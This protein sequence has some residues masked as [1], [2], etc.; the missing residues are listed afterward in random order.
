MKKRIKIL[1]DIQYYK[2][3]IY[4]VPRSFADKLIRQGKAEE[5]FTQKEEKQQVETKEEK[6]QPG[7][8][9]GP[10]GDYPLSI[11]KLKL[12]IQQLNEDILLDIIKHDSRKGA[13]EAAEEEIARRG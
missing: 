6:H 11:P 13:R 8:T 7:E 10:L 3:G 5:V 2:K 1:E 9:K 12:V 4:R